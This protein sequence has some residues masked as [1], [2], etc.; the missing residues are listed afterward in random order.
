MAITDGQGGAAS[1]SGPYKKSKTEDAF[2]QQMQQMMQM[3][4]MAKMQQMA[5]EEQL[6][7]V[8]AEEE[9]EKVKAEQQE[10]L[11]E[12]QQQQAVQKMKDMK[13][14]HEKMQ[15][16]QMQAMQMQAMQVQQMQMMKMQQMEAWRQARAAKGVGK[17]ADEKP[18]EIPGTG[19]SYGKVTSFSPTN[20]FGF[21]KVEG[22]EVWM[23]ESEV[24]FSENN[25]IGMLPKR[26]DRLRFDL[27]P[28]L[29]ANQKSAINITGGTSKE[30]APVKRA[31][32]KEVPLLGPV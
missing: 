14:M 1:S 27:V 23:G 8:E 24:Y 4:Q 5:L 32:P 10:K 26:G 29:K 20:G 15:M 2:E 18:K 16:E 3:Q 12:L 17:K 28:S 11:K 30:P 7:K 19:E 22:N 9:I 6:Q 21:I 25:C 13:E 31:V